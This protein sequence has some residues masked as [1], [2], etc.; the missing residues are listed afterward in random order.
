MSL[1]FHW[2]SLLQWR[3]HCVCVFEKSRDG[4]QLGGAAVVVARDQGARIFD[5]LLTESQ[6]PAGSCILGIRLTKRQCCAE[7]DVKKKGINDDWY[8]FAEFELGWSL[9]CMQLLK[10]T[11]KRKLLEFSCN[12]FCPLSSDTMFP[13]DLLRRH[14][15]QWQMGPEIWGTQSCLAKHTHLYLFRI[16][17]FG[18][19]SPLAVY[20]QEVQFIIPRAERLITASPPLSILQL[21]RI[22]FFF[23]LNQFVCL[24]C[25]SCGFLY[26]V[27]FAMPG[28]KVQLWLFVYRGWAPQGRLRVKH[29]G[30]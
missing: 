25:N 18:P 20:K 22:P 23:F 19:R 4:V 2:E 17:V 1:C 7:D 11:P 24:I 13:S 12:A 28:N 16:I 21:V 10:L 30:P 15:E 27:F 6:R 26:L 3:T 9:S 5:S 8:D 29:R 14:G